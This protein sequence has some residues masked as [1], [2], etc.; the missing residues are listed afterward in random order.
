MPEA[1]SANGVGREG[2]S[3]GALRALGTAPAVAA[4]IAGLLYSVGALIRAAE[5]RD[6]GLTAR[7]TF[8]LQRVED[9]L[10]RGIQVV[11]EPRLLV[12]LLVLSAVSVFMYWNLANR[13]R[14]GTTSSEATSLGRPL[15]FAVA[16]ALVTAL[17]ILFFLPLLFA[18]MVLGSIPLGVSIFRAIRAEV[19]PA[20]W[21][22]PATVIAA[23]L[24]I[25]IGT[26]VVLNTLLT[27]EPLPA[28]SVTTDRKD[29]RGGLI[30]ITGEGLY[31]DR[32]KKGS[33]RFIPTD[34]LDS[35]IQL[36]SRTL[37]PEQRA[38]RKNLWELI[39]GNY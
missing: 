39:R 23:F 18:G 37:P 21:Q 29:V 24:F 1:K 25:G 26:A 5:L 4:I 22:P 28:A 20:H 14:L 35:S 7:D 27:P 17:L 33:Y 34:H 19:D 15:I 32:K 31:L 3:N 38:S 30:A 9:H 16:M 6:A 11:V 13:P 2:E 10:A 12:A 36:Q 8:T